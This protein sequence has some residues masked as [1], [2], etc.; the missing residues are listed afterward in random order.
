[1]TFI[2]R[3]PSILVLFALVVMCVLGALA[4]AGALTGTQVAQV[5]DVQ[6]QA[7]EAGAVQLTWIDVGLYAGAALFF[8][9]AAIRLIRRTQGFW[10]WLLGFACYGGRW[11][12]AQGN[13]VVDQIKAIDINAYRQPEALLQDPASTQVQVAVLAVVLVVG[14]LVFIIDAA[15]RAYWDR[16][17]G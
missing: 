15:D 14:I 9:I 10:T 12:Y 6:A 1:M 2:L 3:W 11:A 5:A 13:G 4:G 16:Q 7:A 8:L 17:G